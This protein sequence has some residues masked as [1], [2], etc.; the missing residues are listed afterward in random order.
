MKNN[1]RKFLKQ[2]MGISAA[3]LISSGLTAGVLN[4]FLSSTA[5]AGTLG[6]YKAIVCLFFFGGQDSLDSILPYDQP[7]YDGYADIR[8]ELLAKYADKPVNTRARE[9]IL[10][11][12]PVNAADFAGRQFAMVPE[13]SPIKSLFDAGNAAIIGNVGPLIRPITAADIIGENPPIPVRVMSHNDQQSTWMSLAP[14]GNIHGW[15]G[16]FADKLVA[17]GVN[18]NP[19]FT[20]I[21]TSPSGNVVF[22][23]GSSIQPFVLNGITGKPTSI[24]GLDQQEQWL[25]GSGNSSAVIEELIRDRYKNAGFTGANLFAQ[26]MK[27]IAQDAFDGS[28][29][30]I[31]A[32]NGVPLLN[33]TFPDD[34]IGKQLKSIANSIN[35]RGNLGTNRQIFFASPAA[36]FDT[37]DNQANRLPAN[38]SSYAQAVAAFYQATVEMGIENDVLL[39][40]ASEF[41]RSLITNGD[42]TDHGWGAHHFVVGGGVSGNTIYGDIP[43]YEIGHDYDYERGHLIPKVSVEQYAAT[44]GKWFGLSA[45]EILDTMPSLANFP[46]TDLGFMG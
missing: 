17:A 37:H 40:T 11:L 16:L 23:A 31:A 1:R 14:E 3:P 15:G 43:P 38:Q 18:S 24:A 39:F 29:E 25:Y 19:R 35:I 34:N 33:T 12:N 46:I 20:T 28:A 21:N 13:L 36:G 8:S 32:Q 9:N 45:A 22:Q 30:F 4:A 27:N 42:G 7:S 2:A 41:G 10:P 26:D 6:G 5:H 44:M